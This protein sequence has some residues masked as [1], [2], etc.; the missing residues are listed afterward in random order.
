[1]R[2]LA[3][4]FLISGFFVSVLWSAQETPEH[5][6]LDEILQ[7]MRK[8][9]QQT[10]S[11]RAR[12]RL[13]R[14]SRIFE[15]KSSK[16]GVIYY[17]RPKQ[18]RMDIEKPY[19]KRFYADEKRVIEYIPD[20][21][22]VHWWDLK[23]EEEKPLAEGGP[24]RALPVGVIESPEEMQKYF[25][26]SL[27][28]Y[29]TLNGKRCALLRLV[30]KDDSVETDYRK[31]ILWLRLEDALPIRIKGF[32]E[33]EEDTYYFTKVELNPELPPETFEFEVPEGVTVQRR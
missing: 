24:S 10:D 7:K 18:F 30:P 20:S 29:E 21:R 26:I 31:V 1:L 9:S 6:E 23:P 22:V 13:E 14:Y 25:S 27:D 4:V 12:F 19:P 15:E 16:S 28:G 2:V 3:G 33:D 5:K 17:A 11:L 32:R 8:R